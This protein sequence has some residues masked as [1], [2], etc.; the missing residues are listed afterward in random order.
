MGNVI[1]GE[2]KC[3]FV[4]VNSQRGE[5]VTVIAN[6]VRMDPKIRNNSIKNMNFAKSMMAVVLG[7]MLVG[8]N[9]L[10]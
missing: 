4:A 2:V 1:S 7:T 8:G 6:D 5:D 3:E 9:A 10:A